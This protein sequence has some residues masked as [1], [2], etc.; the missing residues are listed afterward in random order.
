[1]RPKMVIEIERCVVE[2]CCN[3][4]QCLIAVFCSALLV[5]GIHIRIV[6]CLVAVYC[7]SVLQCV[8]VCCSVML[9]YLAAA[10]C[11]VLQCLVAVCRGALLLIGIHMK[12]VDA[13]F[14][15]LFK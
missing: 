11:S 4:L 7:C 13:T 1:M 15:F 14:R 2:V 9:Q 8:V 10:C 5:I 12:I 3:V 6:Q